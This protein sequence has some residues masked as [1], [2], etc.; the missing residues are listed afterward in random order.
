MDRKKQIYFCFHRW[1]VEVVCLIAVCL[2]DDDINRPLIS[3]KLDDYSGPSNNLGSNNAGESTMW[4]NRST[5][6]PRTHTHPTESHPIEGAHIF[7]LGLSSLYYT[8][9]AHL[10]L[11][12]VFWSAQLLY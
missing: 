11:C 5:T 12:G 2:Q 1:K 9:A 6:S 3:D 4:T 8:A 7:T 10:I